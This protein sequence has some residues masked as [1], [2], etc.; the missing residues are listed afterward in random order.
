MAS[1]QR[2]NQRRKNRFNVE[3]DEDD[4]DV[5]IKL[6]SVAQQRGKASAAVKP[7]S[8]LSFGDDVD[9]AVVVKKNKKKTKPRGVSV[10][11][12]ES[13]GAERGA[14]AYSASELAQLLLNTPQMPDT[15]ASAA[16]AE[17]EAAQG[18]LQAVDVRSIGKL[19]CF[20]S[21]QQFVCLSCTKVP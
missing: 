21:L 18:T 12:L 14:S 2:V 15:F 16:T 19:V 20:C 7:A 10:Q 1:R 4:D 8:K 5:S 17:P 9:E 13:S 6:Q 11:T 3:S